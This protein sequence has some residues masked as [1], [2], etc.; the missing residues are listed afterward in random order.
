MSTYALFVE[1][2]HGAQSGIEA[3]DEGVLRAVRMSVNKGADRGRAEAARRIGRQLN[4]P[5]RY[6]TGANGKLTVTRKA[7]NASLEAAIGATRRATS[8][9]RFAVDRSPAASKKRGGVNVA[10]K[11]GGAKFMPR[12]FLIRLRSGNRSI[13]TASNLGL[14]IRLRPGESLSNKKLNAK[15]LEGNLFLLYGPS[16]DQAFINAGGTG[17]A[18][19]ITPEILDNLESEF[20]RLMKVSI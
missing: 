1:G 20:L 14:A 4:F 2:L 8:L 11:P 3:L 16:V 9:A 18:E 6:I 7:T 10:V 15:R 13:E 17:V 19:D 12:A 5:A